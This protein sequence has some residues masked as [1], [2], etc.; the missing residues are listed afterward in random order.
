MLMDEAVV[1]PNLETSGNARQHVEPV[2]RCYR[3]LVIIVLDMMR[4]ANVAAVIEKVD[5][6]EGHLP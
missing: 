3:R 4:G 6:V 1:L 5:A 2:R